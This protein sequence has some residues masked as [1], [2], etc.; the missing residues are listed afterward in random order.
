MIYEFSGHGS[1]E[2]IHWT[3]VTSIGN[4]LKILQHSCGK[5]ANRNNSDILTTYFLIM[6]E[7]RISGH[8]CD[9]FMR[10]T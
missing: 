7:M 2:I 3:A 8:F 10:F 9:F 6:P 5:M 4:I 1:Q